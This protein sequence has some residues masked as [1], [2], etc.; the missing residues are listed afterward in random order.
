MNKS[1]PHLIIFFDGICYLC[2]SIVNFLIKIDS[3]DKLRFS[4]I[5]S[6]FSHKNFLTSYPEL[7]HYDS[8]LLQKNQKVFVKSDA[9]IEI[10]KELR[11]Y[12]RIFLVG[13][14][15]PRK[16]RD[17]IYDYVAEN[18]YGWFGKKD[19]CMIPT[20]EVKS[21]FFLE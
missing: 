15:I 13:K 17:M 6:K 20:D 18:R 19:E 12:W 4:P 2:N 8:I 1:D 10:I 9:V 11:W 3:K 21:R 5:Q 7:E 14:I 16:L